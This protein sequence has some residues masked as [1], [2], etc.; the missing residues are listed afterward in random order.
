M[1]A[2]TPV[3]AAALLVFNLHAIAGET[4][5][6]TN[7]RGAEVFSTRVIVPLPAELWSGPAPSMLLSE[8]LPV[9]PPAASE[10]E[11]EAT[12]GRGTLSAAVSLVV[13]PPS[14]GLLFAGLAALG[15]VVRRRMA[16]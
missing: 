1:N 4:T 12:T 8:P 13:E 15:Y 5:V 6:E 10:K 14:Y 9:E 2:P 7:G 11:D 16:G 3:L